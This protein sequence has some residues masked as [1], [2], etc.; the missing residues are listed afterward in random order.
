MAPIDPARHYL[1]LISADTEW[2]AIKQVLMVQPVQH[3]PFGE[4]FPS[5]KCIFLQG[6]WGKINAA[7]STQYAIDRWQP[8]L[9]VNLGT[10][11]GFQGKIESGEIVLAERTVVYD[12]IERMGDPDSHIAFYSTNLDLSWLENTPS[13]V[14]RTTLVSADQD[15]AP[16][17]ISLL[18]LKYSAVAGDWESGAIAYVAQKNRVPLL[19]LRYVT[20]LVSSTG[21][22][23]Y[24]DLDLFA[25]RSSFAMKELVAQLPAWLETFENAQKTS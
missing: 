1:I 8:D 24:G 9:L 16:E 21:D 18:S 7:A 5:G 20:D 4:W 14:I 19:I 3:S 15:L 12:I 25:T 6:G 2:L 22:D 23:V 17:N 10:C 11:G 13:P